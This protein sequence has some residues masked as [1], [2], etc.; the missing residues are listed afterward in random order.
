MSI[1]ITIA[2]GYRSRCPVFVFLAF[3]APTKKGPV[4]T[5]P[6]LPFPCHPLFPSKYPPFITTDFH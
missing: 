2:W 1:M 5:L 4:E 3:C 6:M